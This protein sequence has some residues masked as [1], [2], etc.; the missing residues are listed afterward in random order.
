[1]TPQT[2]SLPLT[3][4]PVTF[5]G[6][7]SLDVSK[8]GVQ[9]W[10]L[11]HDDFLLYEEILRSNSASCA[12]G[13]RLN[14]LSDTSQLTIECEPG[15]GA[16]NPPFRFDLFVDGQFHAR[17]VITPPECKTTF[18]NLPQGEHRL[19]V[20]LPHQ[21][22]VRIRSV[23]ID[24]D[25]SA[26]PWTD[27]R[28]RW[29]VYGSSITQCKNSEGPS[30]TWPALVA[31]RFGLNL[32]CMGYGGNCHME[33]VVTR[34]LRDQPA[35]YI[36]LCLGINMFGGST[37]SNRTFR[38][39][40]LGTLLTLRDR[41]R[42]TP[43]VVVTPISNPPREDK[44]NL[45][46]MTLTLM[47]ETITQAVTLLQERGDKQLHL[48]NGLDLFGP[49]FAHHMPDGLHP[50]AQGYHVLADQYAKVVM[51]AFGLKDLQAV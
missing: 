1:M 49:E 38:A 39:G 21:S 8:N 2:Q 46:G 33:P 45:V 14:L 32:T 19:E 23:A 3:G 10:R 28:P 11:V 41:H 16:A 18:A 26:K 51:P 5:A 43:I 17:Q 36:S 13:V 27:P 24:A 15:Q 25:A 44:P 12:T 35:D 20:Y 31:N 6:A 40:V 4:G 34:M 7:I 37:Y 48:I 50:D 9:P 42:N 30:E 29:L 47:R 22:S